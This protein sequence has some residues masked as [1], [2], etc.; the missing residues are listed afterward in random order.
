MKYIV[1]LGDGMADEP[2]ASLHNK[3][4]L[5]AAKK[6]NIDALAKK[7]IVGLADTVPDDM[8]PGSDVANLSVL[9]F[10]PHKSYSGRSPL[11]ALS[12]GIDMKETDICL[13]CNLVT[14]S[15]EEPYED[16]V[17]L[18]HSSD[19]ITTEEAAVLLAA[20]DEAFSDERHKFYPGISY[21]HA[22]I[23]DH[24]T[25]EVR[26]KPPHDILDQKI[27]SYLPKGAS[28]D[29]FKDMMKRSYEILVNHPVNLDRAA[30]GLK[31]ANSIWLWGEGVKPSLDSFEEKY[32]KK[33]A[34]I[35]AVS[36]LKGIAIGAGMEN[37]EVEGAN[38][39]LHTNYEGKA[40]ACLDI[41][42]EGYDFVYLHVEAPDECG[43]RGEL[44]NKILSIEYIDD[45]IVRPIVKG[46]EA[47][48]CDY[49][50]LVMPDHPTPIAYRTHT[51]DPVPFLIY[52]S[53]VA[54]NSGH[55]YSE[56]EGRKSGIF[57][58]KGHEL[59]GSFLTDL[60]LVR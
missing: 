2:I 58:E 49:R 46:L 38:G 1:I 59:M 43:H 11:E 51:K 36:L 16:K 18:D 27:A 52:D 3:T 42:A 20:I 10:D 24:G 56:A 23:W 32:G 29:V 47:A 6:P 33:G 44:E 45:R 34:M 54:Y 15:D 7:G 14:L 12:M 25:L 4:P 48:G 21:R 50:I 9:G 37:L 31:K 5:E 40:Q 22:M 26:M 57:V 39:S 19:E 35:S 8:A 41:L 13:R 28:S 17:M 55:T 60:A 53:T 30:R